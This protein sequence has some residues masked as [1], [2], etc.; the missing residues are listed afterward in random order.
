MPLRR[1]LPVPAVTSSDTGPDPNSV[2]RRQRLDNRKPRDPPEQQVRKE[3]LE[4]ANAVALSNFVNREREHFSDSGRCGYRPGTWLKWSKY[5]KK[6]LAWGFLPHYGFYIVKLHNGVY[7]LGVAVP[8]ED[9]TFIRDSC[10]QSLLHNRIGTHLC[11]LTNKQLRNCEVYFR[12]AFSKEECLL[13]KIAE[14][15]AKMMVFTH[16]KKLFTETLSNEAG[17]FPDDLVKRLVTH[18]AAYIK[19][20]DKT[21][22]FGEKVLPMSQ[23]R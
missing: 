21:V 15:A 19:G 4:Q 5:G 20:I 11:G 6:L 16:N 22:S 9:S 8:R 3:Q 2:R 14:M 17:L 13:V 18:V 7:K 1:Y 12:A 10:Q 23:Y